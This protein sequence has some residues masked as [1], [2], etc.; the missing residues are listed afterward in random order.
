MGSKIQLL[1]RGVQDK[2][3]F[4]E[5]NPMDSEAKPASMYGSNPFIHRYNR[6]MNIMSDHKELVFANKPQFGKSTYCVVPNLGAYLQQL[7]IRIRL[8]SLVPSSGTTSAWTNAIG[9]AI[10]KQITLEIGGVVHGSLTAGALDIMNETLFQTAEKEVHRRMVGKFDFFTYSQTGPNR[11]GLNEEE[12]FA[13]LPFWFTNSHAEAL[14]PGA[15]SASDVIIRVTFADFNE[16][17]VYDGSTPPIFSEIKSASILAKY[18]H[19]DDEYVQTNMIGKSLLYLA[20]QIQIKTEYIPPNRT[21]FHI[22]LEFKHPVSCILWAFVEEE[23]ESNNDWFNYTRRS[24]GGAIMESARFELEGFPRTEM[25]PE[26]HYRI[27]QPLENSYCASEKAVY[28]YNFGQGLRFGTSPSGS[29]N[30]SRLDKAI[31][32]INIRGGPPCRICLVAMNW[33]M[34]IVNRGLSSMMFHA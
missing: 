16:C 27:L 21:G 30:F 14:P 6:T 9:F 26:T 19:L 11:F 10:I 34:F 33:N 4:A 7:Y 32:Y 17:V 2:F 28:Q 23:S 31:M 18:H 24:D 29:V 12:V 13:L 1:A 8:P 3:L 22:E 25:L 15:M 5:A 20:N